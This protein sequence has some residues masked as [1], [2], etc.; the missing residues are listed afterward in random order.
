MRVEGGVG[1]LSTLRARQVCVWQWLGAMKGGT[2][3]KPVYF[4]LNAAYWH[5]QSTL[6]ECFHGAQHNGENICV[7]DG[8]WPVEEL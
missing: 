2:Q 8:C 7:C 3:P 4:V 1:T 5:L 6:W